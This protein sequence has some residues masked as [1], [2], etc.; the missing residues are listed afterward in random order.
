LVVW[1]VWEWE[2]VTNSVSTLHHSIQALLLAMTSSY[3]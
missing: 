1:S 3:V 2:P